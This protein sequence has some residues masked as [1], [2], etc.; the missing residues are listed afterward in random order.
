MVASDLSE[1]VKNH[2]DYC[3]CSSANEGGRNS[4]PVSL[5]NGEQQTDN[6]RREAGFTQTANTDCWRGD[7]QG[8][9]LEKSIK[10]K[11]KNNKIIYFLKGDQKA[12]TPRSTSVK[13]ERR[14]DHLQ[15]GN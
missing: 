4:C 9:L 10:N 6:Q 8:M 14:K 15:L 7:M 1:Q 11:L 13:G 5:Q 3:P 12:C 2:F